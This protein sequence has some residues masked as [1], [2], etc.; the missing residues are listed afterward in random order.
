MTVKKLGQPVP[1]SNFIAE[2]KSGRP[3][4][5]HAKMPGR[6]SSLSGL[7][8]ARSVPSSRMTWKLSAGRRLRHSS[9]LSFT[10]SVGE[11]QGGPPGREGF[12]VFF[13]LLDVFHIRGWRGARLPGEARQ[14]Q[15]FQ[16]GTPFH[17]S[18]F[19]VRSRLGRAARTF[20]TVYSGKLKRMETP[21][22]AAYTGTAG[23][24]TTGAA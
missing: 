5:A 1:E 17:R 2:V 9:L 14:C 21:A 16:Q 10:G 23:L 18:P 22:G 3:Q 15:C 4:P 6:F 11:G 12:P 13:Q 8:P 19:R 7:L 20:L 24:T